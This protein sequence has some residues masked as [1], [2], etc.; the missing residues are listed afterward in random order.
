LIAACIFLGV[1]VLVAGSGF[2]YIEWR[3]GQLHR[4]ALSNLDPHDNVIM[5]VLLVGSDSR[6][7]L[8]GPDAQ[9]AG[10][11]L[12]GGER[13]DTIMI[14]HIDT[15]E[16]KAAIL[17]IPRDLYVPIAGTNRHDRINSAFNDG[18][19]RLIDTIQQSLGI[20]IHHYAEVD[21]VGF[22]GIVDTVG[23]VKMYVPTPV[24]DAFSGLNIKTPGCINFDGEMA[25][26]WVRSRHYQ[27]YEAGRWKEDPTSDIG[28]IQR[29][30]EFIRRM[31]KKAVSSGLTNPFRLD[32]LISIGIK[33][34]TVDN[35]LS[36]N[37]IRRLAGRFRSLDPDTVDMLT[38]KTTSNIVRG[39]YTGERLVQ[40]DAQAEIDRIN[41]V[42]AA[43]SAPSSIR[44]GDVRLRVLNGVGASGLA[45][46][47][48][49]ALSD[50]GFNVA[51][52]GDA[53]AFKYPRT[54]IRY[55]TGELPKAQLV[56]QRLIAG[57]ELVEDTTLRTVD[58]ALVVGS[59]YTGV[60][61]GPGPTAPPT[62]VARP[63]PAPPAKGA[64][65]APAC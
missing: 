65:S 18:P 54:V 29:Q 61:S 55:A 26:Q 31:L 57:G 44:P 15:R 23:G 33:Y 35:A 46:R 52:K 25:L 11:G 30:Q 24:R 38:L 63:S 7:R 2:A 27:Y 5:N 56:Q 10:K 49:V 64:P 17:S 4:L 43:S 37:D 39:Q 28:R 48:S 51:D 41:G 21:F 50:S 1:C 47:V 8:T 40:P 6:A 34:V 22:K 53:D 12:V 16:R 45:G 20:T 36:T 62:T 42:G 59:D 3:L 14:L 32:H 60:R 9:Q 58:V 19:Q 13:S